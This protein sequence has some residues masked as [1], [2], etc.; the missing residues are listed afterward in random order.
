MKA[1]ATI[2]HD[3]GTLRIEMTLERKEEGDEAIDIVA[4]ACVALRPD[5]EFADAPGDPEIQNAGPAAKGKRKTAD[6]SKPPRDGSVTARVLEACR[7]LE[8]TDFR[9]VADALDLVDHVAASAI[10]NPR[11]GGHLK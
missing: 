5:I 4:G 10:A 11:K 7:R 2:D 8:T 9:T 1:I 6:Y 3:A